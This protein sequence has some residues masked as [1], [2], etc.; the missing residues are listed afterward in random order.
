MTINLFRVQY[1][2]DSCTMGQVRYYHPKTG[3]RVKIKTSLL[4][5]QVS[6][7]IHNAFYSYI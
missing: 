3:Y 2:F 4:P 5:P 7:L 1:G 6:V